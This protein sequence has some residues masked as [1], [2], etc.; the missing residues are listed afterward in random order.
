[1]KC[2]IFTFFFLLGFGVY[3]QTK[4]DY[5]NFNE[6][7]AK[8]AF[9]KAFTVFRDTFTIHHLS[10]P[11]TKLDSMSPDMVKT[12]QLRK[13]RSSDWLYTNLSV[14]NCQK[15][16]NMGNNFDHVDVTDWLEINRNNLW[17]NGIKNI[18]GLTPSTSFD[19]LYKENIFQ[20][21]GKFETYD[22]LAVFI[23]KTWDKSPRHSAMMRSENYS[24][25]K[26]KKNNIILTAIYSCS[27]KYDKKN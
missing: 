8:E 15:I 14:K 20:Y 17:V 25:I 27:I 21:T 6:N 23:I 11:S 5:D 24:N 19:F 2:L 22:E 3:S 10:M 13:M 4:I 16:I 12:P 26:Y 18:K 1:M 7:T 9:I